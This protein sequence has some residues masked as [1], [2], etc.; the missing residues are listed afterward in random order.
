MGCHKWS[1]SY[2]EKASGT[3]SRAWWSK[4]DHLQKSKSGV[5]QWGPYFCKTCLLGPSFTFFFKSESPNATFPKSRCFCFTFILF[6]NSDFNYISCKQILVA[7]K[8]L[9]LTCKP[10][11][12][13]IMLLSFYLFSSIVFVRLTLALFL[14]QA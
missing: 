8:G 9:S 5:P 12:F 11:A 10:I 4:K 2:L 14:F 13:C 7:C 6:L 3:Y 1:N